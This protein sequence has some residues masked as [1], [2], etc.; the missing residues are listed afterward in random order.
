MPREAILIHGV[1]SSTKHTWEDN[2]WFDLLA[3]L[4]ITP[5]A[6]PI[7]GHVGST[8]AADSAVAD[9]VTDIL[10][11][12]PSAD[13]IIGFSAGA[14][15][16]LHAALAAPER[17]RTL[18]LLGIGD[19]FWASSASHDET[20]ER[21]RNPGGDPFSRLL[22]A[23]ISSTGNDI[24][25]VARY[26]EMSPGPPAREEFAGIRARTLLACGDRD[27]VG[28]PTIMGTE[29]ARCEVVTLPG[30]DHLRT[31]SAMSAMAAVSRF[32]A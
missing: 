16:A 20:A 1:G 14:S 25:D 4:G 30:V 23:T 22:R 7:P 2:G 9:I 12:H 15:L 19:G 26:I 5:A 28:P 29:L 18:A 3:D 21:L 31:P 32:L 27:P 8:L 17:I 6:Y 13:T 24:D 11:S 10:E